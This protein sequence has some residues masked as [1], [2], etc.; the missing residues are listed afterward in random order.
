M[1]C[2]EKHRKNKT[3][4]LFLLGSRLKAGLRC[5]RFTLLRLKSGF[6]SDESD[7]NP[8]QPD[9]K[10]PAQ[11]KSHH[12]ICSS[13]R[14]L[15]GD[16]IT[17]LSASAVGARSVRRG[18]ECSAT[19]LIKMRADANRAADECWCSALI[20]SSRGGE[21][22]PMRRE[23]WRRNTLRRCCLSGIH[24]SLMRSGTVFYSFFKKQNIQLLSGN[25]NVCW[26]F[27]GII[28]NLPSSI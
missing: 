14:R 16:P 9:G 7:Y 24:S 27:R 20:Q 23:T 22:A 4:V 11:M 25:I 6:I 3:S 17:A 19:G 15:L 8:S 28:H 13:V 18:V 12:V 1:A 26:S 21:S 10:S 2:E 5:E